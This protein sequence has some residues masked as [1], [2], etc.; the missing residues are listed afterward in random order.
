MRSLVSAEAAV[1]LT[2]FRRAV[3][4]ISLS[5][6]VSLSAFLGEMKGPR[7]RQTLLVPSTM[8]VL[9]ENKPKTEKPSRKDSPP[10][11]D[12][13]K[14]AVTDA[15]PDNPPH[16]VSLKRHF[17]GAG[18]NEAWV[19][20]GSLPE[21]LKIPSFERLWELHP[22]DLGEIVL[23]GKRIQTPR[24]VASYGRTYFFSGVKHDAFP[25]EDPFLKKLCAFASDHAGCD[26]NGVLVNWY[27]D[28][29]HYIGWHSDDESS[30][31]SGSPIYSFTFA[32]A[33]GRRDFVVRDKKKKEK[34]RTFELE[35]NGLLI[36]GGS[37][38][39]SLF[40]HSVPK[41]APSKCPGRRINVTIRAFKT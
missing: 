13:G 20:V 35:N 41:R 30:M 38:F 6:T 21:D 28:G 39:Q 29:S 33:G 37:R 22:K 17:L 11:N 27:Q 25:L 36:M 24:W 3:Y 12:A 2:F 15:S 16:S 23:Y 9:K 4:F 40:Q 5:Q 1:A 10:R 19:D 14:T 18:E 32:E 31:V 7:F 26:M 34:V 8:K